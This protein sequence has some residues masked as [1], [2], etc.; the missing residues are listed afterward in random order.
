[1]KPSS[2]KSI[3]QLSRD[4]SFASSFV[5]KGKLFCAVLIR[6]VGHRPNKRQSV[7][8]YYA[9]VKSRLAVYRTNFDI[10]AWKYDWG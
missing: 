3:R 6:R 8:D 5:E 9:P 4:E 10:I 2:S 1:M 7:W